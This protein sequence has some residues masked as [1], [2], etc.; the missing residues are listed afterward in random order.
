MHV[1]YTIVY[2]A[3]IVVVL[4]V[5][6]LFFDR[7]IDGENHI[8]FKYVGNRDMLFVINNYSTQMVEIDPS[9]FKQ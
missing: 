2:L 5:V 4:L 9:V 3:V 7:K 6:R 8:F 1:L